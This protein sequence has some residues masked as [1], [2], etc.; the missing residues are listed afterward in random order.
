MIEKLLIK[1]DLDRINAIYQNGILRQK[2]K[3]GFEFMRIK[4]TL[5]MFNL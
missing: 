5:F 2:K 3:I 4:I 1:M